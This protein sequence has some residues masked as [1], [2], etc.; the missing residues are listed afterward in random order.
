MQ[1]SRGSGN[2]WPQQPLVFTQCSHKKHSLTCQETKPS[3]TR[4]QI[5]IYELNGD[6]V[7]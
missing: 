7:S 4:G 2:G 1:I 6:Y 3:E 5:P